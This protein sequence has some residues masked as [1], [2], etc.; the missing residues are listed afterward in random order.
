MKWPTPAGALMWPASSAAVVIVSFVVLASLDRTAA[1]LEPAA[2]AVRTIQ[3]SAAPPT[4]KPQP[5]PV[6][7]AAV[8]QAERAAPIPWPLTPPVEKLR[9]DFYAFPAGC[10][11]RDG[12]TSSKL[13]R[14]GSRSSGKTIV[15][16][17]DSHAQMWMPAILRLAERDGWV[18]VPLVKTR[19]IPRRWSEKSGECATWFRWAKRQ[20]TR[21]RPQVSLIIGSWARAFAPR[22]AVGP[23]DALTVAMHKFSAR[24]IVVGD[25]PGQPRE[26]VDCLL[27]RDATMKTCTSQPPAAALQA[28]AAIASNAR[29]RGIGFVDTEGWFCA[30]GSRKQL[31]CPL[32][33]DR[34]IAYFDRAHITKTYALKLGAVFRTGFRQALFS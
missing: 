1:R 32:V 12:Q 3:S 20:A 14:L 5:L 31:L 11:P 13:C 30:R 28:N 16:F 18:V 17:G 33:V 9:E 26:P 29:R 27:E 34:T 7:V 8:R 21:L 2:A 24:V 25:A 6:V 15:L 4:R 10:I 19:C 23:V 22:R